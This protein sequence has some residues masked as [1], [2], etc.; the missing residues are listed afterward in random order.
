[1]KEATIVSVMTANNQAEG[2]L[3]PTASIF[4]P[5]YISAKNTTNNP[6][7]MGDHKGAGDVIQKSTYSSL[8]NPAIPTTQSP[9]LLTA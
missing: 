2:T 3:G 4:H 1:M 8:G 5:S 7:G 9:V 6:S